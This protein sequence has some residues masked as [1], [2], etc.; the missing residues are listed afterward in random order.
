MKHAERDR[1]DLHPL[2]DAEPEDEQRE[3]REVRDGALELHRPVDDGLA[4]AAEP[5]DDGQHEA[6]GDPEGQTER[7]ARGSRPAGRGRGGR[8]PTGPR[9]WSTTVHGAER[10]RGS[11]QPCAEPQNHTPSSRSG[12]MRY[13]NGMALPGPRRR[14]PRGR[15]ARPLAASSWSGTA[16]SRVGLTSTAVTAHPPL[17]TPGRPRPRAVRS[18]GRTGPR[19]RARRSRCSSASSSMVSWWRA[20]VSS[21]SSGN[22]GS[23]SRS[24]RYSPSS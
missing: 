18:G 11:I 3:Q 2:A 19:R 24:N 20:M 7:E 8:T 6:G 5:G 15:E 12:P 1:D 9:R 10:T 21:Q 14:L 13:P 23:P 22:S 16:D 17:R 4:P